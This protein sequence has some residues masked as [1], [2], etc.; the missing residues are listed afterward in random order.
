MSGVNLTGFVWTNASGSNQAWNV[1]ALLKNA[2]NNYISGSVMAG[3]VLTKTDDLQVQL[4]YY[5]A[6]N[7]DPELAP[8]GMPYGAST[9]ELA[10]GIRKRRGDTD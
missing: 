4:N 5:K 8:L 2:N 7:Y 10:D 6:D 1:D 3:A 9:K